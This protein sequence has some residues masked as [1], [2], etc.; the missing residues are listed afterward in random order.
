MKEIPV[1]ITVRS[2]QVLDGETSLVEQETSG[3]L[4]AAENGWVLWYAEPA[5]PGDAPVDNTLLLEENRATLTRSGAIRSRMPFVP[6]ETHQISYQTLYGTLD[7][8]VTT[9][10]LGHTVTANGGK[11]M[12]RYEMSALGKTMGTYTLKL[13]IR[14][15]DD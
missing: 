4:S 2:Q 11:V 6:G 8:S 9:D 14:K 3:T 1:T 12:I 5:E 15:K 7:F 13:H 10:Y